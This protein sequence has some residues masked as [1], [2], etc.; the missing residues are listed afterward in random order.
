M[1]YQYRNHKTNFYYL[2]LREKYFMKHYF[3]LIFLFSFFMILG[4]SHNVKTTG[5]VTFSDDGTPLTEGT[6]VFETA[7]YLARGRLN[8]DGTYHLGSFSERDGLPTGTYNVYI[9]GA[10][11]YQDAPN[12]Q[13]VI[14]S[15]IDTKYSDP[16][17]PVWKI[18]ITPKTKQVDLTVD[19]FTRKK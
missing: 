5:K 12:G 9:T 11:Q 7:G 6:V 19:R 10:V 3:F 17:N 13:T 4:C 8:Q 14:N 16:Q 1:E 18:E 15:L 2:I